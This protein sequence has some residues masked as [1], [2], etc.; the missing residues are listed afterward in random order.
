MTGA[1]QMSR[2]PRR[3]HSLAFKTKVAIEAL[4]DGK[5]IAEVELKHDV[6]PNHGVAAAIDRMRCWRVWRRRTV[7]GAT[8][9]PE[10]AARQDRAIGTGE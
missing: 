8:G 3:N 4:G 2:R 5:T 6:H 10:G 9:R 1:E 7:R